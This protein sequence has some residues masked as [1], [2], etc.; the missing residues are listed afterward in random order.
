MLAPP[1]DRLLQLALEEDLAHGDITTEPLFTAGEQTTAHLTARQS[2]IISGVEIA[3]EVFAQVDSRL[4]TVIL[5]Q[6]GEAVTSGTVIM[7][8]SGSTASILKA[9]RLALNFLQH[10]SGVA[11]LTYQFVGAVAGTET[12]ILHT[13]KTTPGLRAL[14]IAAVQH[15]GGYPHRSS[16]AEAVLIKDNHIAAAGS[17]SAA[18]TKIRQAVG[19]NTRIEVECDTLDQVEEAIAAGAD[20]V[21]LDNMP[22]KILKEAVKLCKGKVLTEASGGV[23]LKTVWDIAKTG[24]DYISTSQITLS[25]PAVDIGLDF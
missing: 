8:V 10:L 21:L 7:E 25:A 16:L 23:T 19:A 5:A 9:E 4:T 15:G 1:A 2:A 13:R 12:K 20:M 24:V 3:R 6:D 22:L 18:V 17:V 14:E 11:T